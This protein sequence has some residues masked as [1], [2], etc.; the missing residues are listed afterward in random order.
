MV[1]LKQIQSGL[2][3]SIVTVCKKSV[4]TL[5][6]LI[7]F[8]GTTAKSNAQ[9]SFI[10]GKQFGTEHGEAGHDI[11]IYNN[12]DFVL[13]GSTT[14]SLYSEH[15]GKRDGFIVRF[16]SLGN[17]IWKHQFGSDKDDQPFELEKDQSGNLYV[18]G[19]TNGIING[20][21]HGDQDVL[22]YKFG[23][24]GE[25]KTIKV[26]GTDS[27]EYLSEIYID[28]EFNI[29]LAGSTKG[30]LGRKNFGD[31]DYFVM[32]L[33]SNFNEL[34]TLQFGSDQTEMCNDFLLDQDE[35]FYIVGYTYG[36]L[37]TK[38][39]GDTDAFM[40][41]YNKNGDLI[42]INQFGTPKHENVSNIL[43]DKNDNIYISGTSHGNIVSENFGRNDV[44]FMKLDKDWNIIWEKQFGTKSW[45][46]AWHMDFL[47]D[48]KN[49]I[50]SG[51]H[52]PD[53][54]IRMYDDQ[55][56]LI[57]NEVFAARGIKSGTGGRHF[58]IF[59]DEYLYFTGFTF[60][61]LFSKNPNQK[62]GDVFIVKLGLN[63]E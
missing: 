30:K 14:R 44:F 50:I 27:T 32:K 37:G 45:D 25:L 24:D 23:P 8:F 17:E 36:I 55:G 15:I 13:T 20:Q 53:A 5:L 52:N 16:D 6:L 43:I 10:W 1:Q 4:P 28:K 57:W 51:S 2:L 62:G 48:E 21:G 49:I 40:A 11:V 12:G 26:I 34:Y 42:K 33:D 61:D 58:S 56:K 46:E 9:P 47:N 31:C 3:V 41:H 19:I 63:N 35:G 39:Y 29:Y 22:I 18:A 7:L 60:A 54:Y 38:N 59:N